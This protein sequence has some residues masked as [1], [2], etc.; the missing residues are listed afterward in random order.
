MSVV[1]RDRRRA[2]VMKDPFVA[3]GVRK[4]PFITGEAAPTD[5]VTRPAARSAAA[6][7]ALGLPVAGGAES[8]G[9]AGPR[10]SRALRARARAAGHSVGGG[11]IVTGGPDEGPLI[12]WAGFRQSRVA[13][14]GSR[15]GHA[16]LCPARV[17]RPKA[18]RCAPDPARDAHD[19]QTWAKAHTP[20]EC[21]PS[22]RPGEARSHRVKGPARRTPC[23]RR[24]PLDAV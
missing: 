4:D 18:G 24:W 14:G 1:E 17:A 7:C 13:P 15:P 5:R 6:A 19:P 21:L 12:P 11:C 23:T 22:R 16:A 10:R 8:S 3:L 2:G 20:A 9:E